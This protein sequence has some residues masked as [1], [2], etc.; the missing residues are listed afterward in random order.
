V[1]SPDSPGS[2]YQGSG[3]PPRRLLLTFELQRTAF[4]KK[5]VQRTFS[6]TYRSFYRRLAPEVPAKPWVGA[7]QRGADTVTRSPFWPVISDTCSMNPYSRTARPGV[8][9]LPGAQRGAQP[10]L[11]N[12]SPHRP[13]P[14]RGLAARRRRMSFAVIC[15]PRCGASGKVS[16]RR[17][18]RL[19]NSR[20]RHPWR[21]GLD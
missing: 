17:E 16:A 5:A 21:P 10:D 4:L 7:L 15:T 18:A 20:G 13:L 1:V 11:A 19:P 3:L 6:Y 9:I 12:L 2:S 8:R 14:R